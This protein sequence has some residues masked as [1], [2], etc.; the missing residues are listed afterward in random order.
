MKLFY[1]ATTAIVLAGV[2][3]FH[4]VTRLVTTHIRMRTKKLVLNVK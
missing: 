4:V 3:T 1:I 2:P